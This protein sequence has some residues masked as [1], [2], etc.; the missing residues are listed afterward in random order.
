MLLAVA[1]PIMVQNGITNFVNLL[2]N[3]MVGQL[4]TESMSGISIVNQLIF[5]FNIC[6]FGATSGAGIFTAQ[7]Y[8]S[9]DNDGVR[10]TFRFKLMICL[11]L[12]AIFVT[13]FAVKGEDLIRLYMN[14][15]NAESVLLAVSEGR[16]YL[17]IMVIGLVPFTFSAVYVGT[18]RETGN[19]VPPMVAGI[20][21]VFVNL[22]FNYILIF[23]KLGAPVMGVRGAAVATVIARF[24][25]L[26]II[27]IWTHTHHARCPFMQGVYKS[28]RVP[29][30]IVKRIFVKGA[31]LMLNE[32]LW[33]VG[34]AMI[35]QCYSL[36]GLSA[37]AAM[38]INSTMFNLFSI[39]FIALG[40]SVG[41]II[42]Q[43][44]GAGKMDE[45]RDADR[46]LIF[47]SFLCCIAVGA[48]MFAAS[49]VIPKAYKTSD[50]VRSLATSLI[51]VVA[52]LMPIHAVTHACYFTLRSGGRTFITFLFDSVFLWVVNY[53]VVWCLTH[54]TEM[55][56]VPLYAISS[57]LDLVKVA[58]GLAMVASGVWIRN[59]V[60]SP[61]S[62]EE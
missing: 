2:D 27:V 29:G 1:V 55:H 47:S 17:D 4:G 23:G 28:M 36:R 49:G 60:D 52:V 18:L 35:T 24:A 6:I 54:L 7:F 15:E 25:E 11:V 57:G 56:I 59:I 34:M 31:P 22:V 12:A 5:V 21:A 61:D 13:G 48:L 3:I 62:E 38:N 42:G 50:E 39:V 45:A 9:G 20:A 8:G 14:D 58:I 10:A 37:V 40:S 43:L 51:R 16:G 19:T 46:K 33:S 30:T 44:L 53:P 26:A 32:V 41:I